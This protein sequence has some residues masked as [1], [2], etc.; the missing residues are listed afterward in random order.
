M[1]TS[2]SI[3]PLKK[4]DGSLVTSA[5]DKSQILNE[6]FGSV[7]TVDDGTKPYFPKRVP[8]TLSQISFTT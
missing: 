7:F 3:A 6:F 5:F 8:D 1:C 4:Q 2:S